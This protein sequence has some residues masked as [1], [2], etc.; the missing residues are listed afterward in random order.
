MDWEDKSRNI[1]LPH[2]FPAPKI[3]IQHKVK[4]VLSCVSQGSKHKSVG[5]EP[6]D[7]LEVTVLL[8]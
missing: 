1:E 8:T 2:P 6:R 3:C 5:N 7:Y 4:Q